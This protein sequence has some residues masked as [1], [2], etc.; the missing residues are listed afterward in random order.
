MH[1]KLVMI[2]LQNTKALL[3]RILLFMLIS[4]CAGAALVSYFEQPQ[5]QLLAPLR[6]LILF[7][8]TS[9]QVQ[10][11]GQLH[12]LHRT[13]TGLNPVTLAQTVR[14][15]SLDLLNN[16][17]GAD[18]LDSDSRD[19][20]LAVAAYFRDSAQER[21]FG[22]IV[23]S[24][25]TYEFAWPVYGLDSGWISG[26]AQGHAIEVLLAA[27]HLTSDPDYYELAIEAAEAL[28]VPIEAGGT[29]V[30]LEKG[31]WFEEY[32]QPGAPPP[33]VLNGHMYALEGL[34]QLIKLEPRFRSLFNEGI[35]AL[36]HL[37]PLFDAGIWSMYDLT[38]IPAQNSYQR[39]HASQLHQLF[40]WTGLEEFDTYSRRFWLQTAFPFSSLFRVAVYPNTYLVLLLL[41]NTLLASIVLVGMSRFVARFRQG[42]YV[43][44][45]GNNNAS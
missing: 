42:T 22:D 25:W 12:N 16:P 26:M 45:V 15:I 9:G 6:N 7:G 29:A 39:V 1:R 41:G 2:K 30:V 43:H 17:D 13:G 33:F 40:I 37:V 23:F 27:H 44:G 32:A 10:V 11:D 21:L 5:K 19:A 8:T 36:R 18:Q 3:V 28:N 24:V 35:E 20:L 34:G 31:I 4:A 14:S 38:G